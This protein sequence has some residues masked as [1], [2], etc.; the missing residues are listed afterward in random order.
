MT[1]TCLS[2]PSVSNQN[3]TEHCPPTVSSI[4]LTG[5]TSTIH[6]LK[7]YW[8]YL[9]YPP[10][11]IKT[12]KL[13]TSSSPSIF[14]DEALHKSN[15]LNTSMVVA[16]ALLDL[17]QMMNVSFLFPHKA[18]PVSRLHRSST[19]THFHGTRCRATK[20]TWPQDG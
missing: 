17:S 7:Q 19:S 15:Q 10:P 12:S 8:V 6:R 13:L 4:F 3:V 20:R 11:Q 14:Y 1:F 16:V 9:N 18:E 2:P 5:F